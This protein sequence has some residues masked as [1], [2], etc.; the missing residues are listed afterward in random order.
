MELSFNRRA[1]IDLN[2]DVI[3]ELIRYRGDAE[4][5]IYKISKRID[6]SKGKKKIVVYYKLPEIDACP[7]IAKNGTLYAWEGSLSYKIFGW[8][9]KQVH[10]R[11]EKFYIDIEQ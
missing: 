10:F 9:E 1:L 4:E 2:A 7:Q 8:M 6:M 3:L 5:E 11:S